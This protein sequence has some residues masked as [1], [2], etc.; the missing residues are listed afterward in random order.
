MPDSPPRDPALEYFYFGF[1]RALRRFRAV[2][3]A[4]WCVAGA[5]FAAVALRWE[6]VWSG[7]LAGGLLCGLLVVAGIALV[8]QGVSELSW[9]TRVPF[10]RPPAVGEGGG[11]LEGA[12]ADL[13]E[14]MDSVDEGGWQDAV[15]ALA[16]LRRVGEQYDLPE[17]D[18]RPR[19]PSGAGQ[20]EHR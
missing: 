4:G 16:A 19:K 8:Q 14:I 18:G 5:G 12:L 13:S 2:T 15:Q 11:G 6:P 9:Y 20:T 3:V 17:P 7:D 10:P 1:F